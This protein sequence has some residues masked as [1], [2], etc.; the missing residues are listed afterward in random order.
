M[1]Y[2]ALDVHKKYSGARTEHTQVNRLYESRLAHAHGTIKNFVKR[3][4][5]GSPVAQLMHLV[6]EG[7]PEVPLS[8]TTALDALSF[9]Q[10]STGG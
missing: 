9:G 7:V 10:Q 1:E 3:W 2:I 5:A 8:L 6:S 4:T